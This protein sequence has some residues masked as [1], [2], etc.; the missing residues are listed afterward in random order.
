MKK[1]RAKDEL[2]P[3]KKKIFIDCGSNVGDTI[4]L[5]LNNFESS[6]EYEIFAFE[7]NEKLTK[8]YNYENTTLIN[9][10]VWVK[11]ENK[12]FLVGIK[13]QQATNSRLVDFVKGRNRNKFDEDPIVV[14]CIDFST[15]IKDNLSKEDYI[16]VKFDIEGSEYDVLRKMIEDD[17]I[18][19]IDEIYIEFHNN[20]LYRDKVDG[21]AM[22]INI[23]SM[24]I[25][26]FG[27]V[28]GGKEFK[29]MFS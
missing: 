28:S 13:N 15:W 9:K 10:A 14:S 22:A 8:N 1:Y 12:D 26:I 25:K 7:P 23:S 4:E 2:M 20:H 17:S 24:G 3:S 18:S 19:Y 11:N 6:E 27:N 5:F 16:V 21:E 29:E